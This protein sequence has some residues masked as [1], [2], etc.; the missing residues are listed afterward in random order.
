M[1]IVNAGV[2]I[3]AMTEACTYITA[4]SLWSTSSADTLSAMRRNRWVAVGILLK[5]V[6]S[7]IFQARTIDLQNI[8]MT[9]D[10]SHVHNHTQRQHVTPQL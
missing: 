4:G 5:S 9:S 2:Y 6:I 7:S 8:S 3:K 1:V 10:S